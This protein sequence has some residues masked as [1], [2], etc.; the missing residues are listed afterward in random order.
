[1]RYRVT[2]TTTYAYEETVSICHNEVRLVPRATRH[3]PE[4][5]SLIEKLI[6]SGHAYE[7][8]G[9]VYY[10]IASR[11]YNK[12]PVTPNSPMPRATQRIIVISP[13]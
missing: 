4:M 2:H 13:S 6:A 5:V 8:E 9:S 11:N 3:I 1:M 10:R 7:S 12:L